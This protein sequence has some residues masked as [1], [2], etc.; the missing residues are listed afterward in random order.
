MENQAR[1]VTVQAS[2]P[3]QFVSMILVLVR[4]ARIM[5]IVKSR[6]LFTLVTVTLDIRGLT[7]ANTLVMA[8]FSV[9]NVK[10]ISKSRS[11]FLMQAALAKSTQL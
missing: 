11:M 6:E 9:S 10:M 3:D 8:T 5:E 4:I 1:L 7:V 2:I